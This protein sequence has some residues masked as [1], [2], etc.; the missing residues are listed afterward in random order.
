VT[1]RP[2]AAADL[3]TALDN[4]IEQGLDGQYPAHPKFNKDEMRLTNA[5]VQQA[6]DKIREALEAPDSRVA[7]DRDTRK[8]L[9]P[10]LEPLELAHVGEQFLAVKT[11]W[12]DRFDPREEQLPNR[13]ATVGHI[14]EMDEPANADGVAEMCW[15]TWS[16]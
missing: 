6:F 10:L 2:P 8:K 15:R 9:R 14:A 3:R 4:L 11:V 13:T 5:L 12:F 1:V 16:S 7:I